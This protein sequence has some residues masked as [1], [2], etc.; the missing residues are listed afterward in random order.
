MLHDRFIAARAK[1]AQEAPEVTGLYLRDIRKFAA[2]LAPD[3]ASAAALLQ[4][5]SEA[6]TRRHY[7]PTAKLRPVR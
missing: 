2:Q 4:H 3:T 1:A 5:S 6:V 7:A